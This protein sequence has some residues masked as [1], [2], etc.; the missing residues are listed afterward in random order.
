LGWRTQ[1]RCGE[2]RAAV[3]VQV[4][5]LEAGAPELNR[6]SSHSELN[7]RSTGVRPCSSCAAMLTV[8]SSHVSLDKTLSLEGHSLSVLK[9]PL[10]TAP[11][12]RWVEIVRRPTMNARA[13]T[14]IATDCHK[15]SV[16]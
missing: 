11:A 14:A 10:A 9:P 7:I 5:W 3:L 12:S 2:G 4:L 6:Q 13:R 8:R 16:E 15:T 1:P